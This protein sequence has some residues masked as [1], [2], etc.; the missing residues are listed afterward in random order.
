M[1][2][3]QIGLLVIGLMVLSLVSQERFKIP[4]PVTLISVVLLLASFGIHFDMKGSTFDELVLLLLPLLITSDVL[5]LSPKEL[6]R[7]WLSVV[8]T[9]GVVVVASIVLGVVLKTLFF[10]HYA[11]SV[12]A[13]VALMAMVVATDPVTVSAVFSNFKLPHSLKFIAESESLFN[14][15]TAF[16]IFGIALSMLVTPMTPL[17]IVTVSVVTVVA[18][19]LVGFVV[20]LLGIVLLKLSKGPQTETAIILLV[21]YLSFEFAEHFDVAAVFSLVV[22]IVVMNMA[23]LSD[24]SRQN[25]HAQLPGWRHR[26]CEHL[27][28]T[29]QNHETIVKFLGFTALLANVIL[30]ISIGDLINL[31]LLL[32]YWREIL[33]VFV[34]TTLIR[35]VMM[36]RFK[37]A[38]LRFESIETISFDWWVVLT[39]AG[40][41][42]GLSILMVHMLP[43][44]FAY[45][46][47]FTAIILGNIILTTFVYSL[48]LTVYVKLHGHRF[49][50]A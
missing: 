45:K 21:A 47:M 3:L 2:L 31:D 23:I 28:D 30:Y 11:L 24:A 36:W 16:V 46:E 4:M 26:L 33:I 5:N 22:S 32:T 10:H 37:H 39:F 14:D 27:N 50:K 38:S 40:V 35:A 19:F 48:I 1:S 12:P 17:Q 15:A 41:K 34:V 42:G 49:A 8:L 25:T 9:A 18:S 6:K 44:S 20:G 43:E 7:N 13:I 29:Y